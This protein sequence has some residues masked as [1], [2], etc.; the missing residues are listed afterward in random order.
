[1]T[2]QEQKPKIEG[3]KSRRPFR[4]QRTEFTSKV[5]GLEDDTFDIGHAKYAAKYA[6]SL[7]AIALCPRKIQA[8]I[9]N[10]RSNVDAKAP[11][12]QSP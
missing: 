10:C 2:E 6:R 3:K 4:P 7:K 8:G 12:S 11:R 1:M 5:V 9:H